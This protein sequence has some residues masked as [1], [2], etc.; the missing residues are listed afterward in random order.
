[1]R[2]RVCRY[3]SDEVGLVSGRVRGFRLSAGLVR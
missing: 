3:V 2:S 1:M